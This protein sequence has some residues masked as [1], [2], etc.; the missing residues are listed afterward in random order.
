MG[1][2]TGTGAAHYVAHLAKA[3]GA[4]VV[5]LVTAPFSFEG[6]R[7]TALAVAGVDQLR[8][9]VDNLI[10]VHNDWL[11]TFVER[12]T[13]MIEAFRTANEVVAQGIMGLSNMINV[14]QEIN[15]VFADVRSVMGNRGG[16][17]MAVGSGNGDTGPFQAARQA[18]AHPPL[19]LSLENA[20]DVLV[21]IK[22]GAATMTLGGVNAARKVITAAVRED[23]KVHIGV[24]VGVDDSLGDEA[25]LTLIATGLRRGPDDQ[26]GPDRSVIIKG[27]HP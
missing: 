5:G 26:T 25:K 4:L 6:R 11:L 7:R 16:A 15:V 8:P 2:G 20:A 22:G 14:A 23:A 18:V 9:Y 19:D 10:L 12:E 3:Q 1:G 17:L 21:M 27:H 13:Q 24:G